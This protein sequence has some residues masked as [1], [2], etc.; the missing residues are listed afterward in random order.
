MI[1]YNNLPSE[2]QRK[3][4]DF[5]LQHP[6]AR[7]INDGVVR[8]KCNRVHKFKIESICLCKI[9]G[10]DFCYSTYLDQF[11]KSS[12]STSTEYSDELCDRL[13]TVLSDTSDND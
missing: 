2:L 1:F 8:L 13:F 4:T 12:T 6:C 7:I 5:V 11:E 10:L 3:V 9:D